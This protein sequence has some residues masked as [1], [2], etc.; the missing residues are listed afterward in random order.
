[1]V[2]IYY[3]RSETKIILIT[4]TESLASSGASVDFKVNIPKC[5]MYPSPSPRD[6]TFSGDFRQK[7]RT[8]YV[9]QNTNIY[10]TPQ[11]PRPTKYGY[12]EHTIDTT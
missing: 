6:H 12:E 3:G 7:C 11:H 10:G 4:A 5:I 9:T 1:M 8:L 2:I